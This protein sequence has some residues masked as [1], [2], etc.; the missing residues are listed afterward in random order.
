MLVLAWLTWSIHTIYHEKKMKTKH[1]GVYSSSSGSGWIVC[2]QE[3][4]RFMS[5]LQHRNNV[6]QTT[7][8][9]KPY[10]TNAISRHLQNMTSWHTVVGIR[11]MLKPIRSDWYDTSLAQCLQLHCRCYSA[12]RYS[13]RSYSARSTFVLGV[14][15]HAQAPSLNA[16]PNRKDQNLFTDS[17]SS[18][19]QLH[20]A[21][22][23][24]N[25]EKNR[26]DVREVLVAGSQ[27]SGVT[28]VRRIACRAQKREQTSEKRHSCAHGFFKRSE[29]L[30][31]GEQSLEIRMRSRG[32]RGWWTQW[33]TLK[34]VR[35]MQARMQRWCSV[36]CDVQ[37]AR[38]DITYWR[39]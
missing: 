22:S 8:L 27:H 31:F 39:A 25:L 19:S 4:T 16:I 26:D 28:P 24:T 36:H 29:I 15:R 17:T 33:T 11:L 2:M 23:F 10:E 9:R 35:L 34:K 38:D 6:P 21:H 1:I 37:T 7:Q 5:S 13:A 18:Y 30:R 3:H 20:S 12:C 32:L 14:T